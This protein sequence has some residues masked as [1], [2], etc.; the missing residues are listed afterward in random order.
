VETQVN[1]TPIDLAW[2]AGLFEG[3]GSIRINTPTRRNRG[4]L[5]V[6]MVNT[7]IE[8]VAIFQDNWPGYMRPVKAKG[9]RKDYYR[10]RAAAL[11]AASFL[12]DV[13]P[14][15]RTSRVRRKALLGLE[16]QAQ[17]SK[18]SSINRTPE[19]IALQL[20]YYDQMTVLNLR[21]L[22]PRSAPRG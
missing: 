21:G 22:T 16:F 8:C 12:V 13:L 2:V 14:H 6:D 11:V 19:Y 7:D 5:V 1:L 18:M 9:N 3:E 17:K 15:L 4:H 20:A 10:Y